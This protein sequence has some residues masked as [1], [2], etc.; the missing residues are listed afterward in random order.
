M[1]TQNAIS[2]NASGLA[3][4]DGAGTFAGRTIQQPAAGI[5]V[6]D[7]DGVSGDPTLA[8]ADDLAA[9]EGLSGSGVVTRTGASAWATNSIADR[10]IVAGDAGNTVQAIGPLSDG[11]L[12][13][14]ATGADPAAASLTAPAAGITITG[15][16][17]TVTFAL[18]DDLAALEGLASTGL[19]ARTASNTW[20]ERTISATS[21]K[22]AVTNGDGVSGNPSIDV[23]EA[24]LTLDNIGGTLSVSKGGTGATTLTGVLTGNGTSAVTAS[25]VTQHSVLLGGASNAVSEVA[26]GLGDLL[27]GANSAAPNDLTSWMQAGNNC[28]FWNLSFT[29][30]A[31]TLTLAGADG[32]ALSSTN[33]GFVVMAS[34]ATT[35]RMVLHT[36]TANDTLTVS[37]MT[38]SLFGTTSSIAW[39]NDMP[40]YV[41]FMADSSDANL[42]PVICRMP[43]LKTSPATSG[44]IGD[45]SSAT[46]DEEW[47]VFAWNDI[48]ETNYTSK[49]VGIIGSLRATKAVTTDAWTLTALDAYDGAGKWN[50]SRTFTMV[51]G[52][53][54]AASGKYWGDEGGTAPSFSG[55][56]EVYYWISKDGRCQYAWRFNTSSAASG[57]GAASL[58]PPYRHYDSSAIN[59]TIFGVGQMRDSSAGVER[60]IMYYGNSGGISLYIPTLVTVGVVPNNNFD[61]GDNFRG[62]IIL[63]L[64]DKE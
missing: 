36:I 21:S 32:T 3:S 45:P 51:T 25:A 59:L 2:L 35:G 55:A 29:H 60:T 49:Q 34:N 61:S 4:Y 64:L 39:G 27:I 26:L 18:S 6:A 58:K 19:A 9:V 31:G 10:A 8:L 1:A 48:T 41:G 50:D 16:T 28:W 14:G 11:E 7:G 43:H 22:I 13:I 44:D 38:G 46:A 37:D 5:T 54:G 57:T 63:P 12:V 62:S 20:A 40:L 17:N 52:N 24:N 47:S 56:N 30:S 53:N 23:T 15:G 33:P 42:E